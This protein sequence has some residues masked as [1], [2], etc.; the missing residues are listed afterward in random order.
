MSP[1]GV[2]IEKGS[3][4]F[5]IQNLNIEFILEIF[6]FMIALLYRDKVTWW[7]K[8]FEIDLLYVLSFIV[9]REENLFI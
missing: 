9:L 6:S 5:N 4:I 8:M 1:F 3:W 7:L 2:C